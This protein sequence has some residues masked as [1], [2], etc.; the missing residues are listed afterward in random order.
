MGRIIISFT[1]GG[2]NGKS[3]TKD[4]NKKI[5]FG[6]GND[7]NIV[8]NGDQTQTISR[9][10]ATIYYEN[11]R[12]M[13]A[14]TSTNGTHLN[15][16]TII[17]GSNVL[18]DG[19]TII[20]ATSGEE[21]TIGIPEKS[22][23]KSENIKDSGVHRSKPSITKILPMTNKGFLPA[24]VSQPFFVPGLATVITGILLITIGTM[25]SI[26]Q[27]ESFVKMYQLVLGIYLGLMMLFFVKHVS[28]IKLPFW[29]LFGT[30]IFTMIMLTL[31]F[32][33][34]IFIMIFRPD[35]ITSIIRSDQYLLTFIGY[36][37]GTGLCEELFK[38]IP[39][40]LILILSKKLSTLN[41]PGF[42]S[43]KLTPTVAM[44]IGSASAIGFIFIETMGQYVPE[45]I[46]DVGYLSSFMI[47]IPRFI[48]GMAGHVGWTGIFSYFIALGF[49][50]NRI[51][52]IYPILGWIFVSILHGLWNASLL[53][54][55]FISTTVALGTFIIFLIYLFKAKN[56]FPDD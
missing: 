41:L 50:F 6:R 35:T 28:G 43:Q 19:D 4:D 16:N 17:E 51:N 49:Y 47:M 42:K 34:T 32:P 38:S 8:F 30:T 46:E 18:S 13:I 2:K 48:T 52:L 44:V 21:I 40:F 45:I 12:W 22:D 15:G 3:F 29:L 36:F 27:E 10:H 26:S 54:S 23:Y 31:S 9:N 39:L 37:V 53:H 5:T 7:N 56:S 55:F 1:G 25:V 14:D 11:D 20:F 24:L 33:F